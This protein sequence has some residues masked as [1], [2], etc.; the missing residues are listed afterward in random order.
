MTQQLFEKGQSSKGKNRGYGLFNVQV[1]I[2]SLNGVIEYS[3]DEHKG[4]IFTVYLPKKEG[5]K[6]GNH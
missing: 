3:S 4:T 5:S 2:E 1:E 6:N